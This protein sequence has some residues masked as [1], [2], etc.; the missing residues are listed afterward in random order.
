MRILIL[1]AIGLLLFLVFR[2]LWRQIKRER[3]QKKTQ[4]HTE[5]MVRCQQC[6]LHLLEKEAVKS[7]ERQ[8]FC[9]TEHLEAFRQDH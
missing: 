7:S 1:L 8:F 6:G 2:N 9:S 4:G 3:E 5:S